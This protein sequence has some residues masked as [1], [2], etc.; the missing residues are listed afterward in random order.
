MVILHRSGE[1]SCLHEQA[2][3]FNSP[4]LDVLCRPSTKRRISARGAYET[5]VIKSQSA[6]RLPFGSQFSVE[7]HSILKPRTPYG[8]SR[9]KDVTRF[10]FS[11]SLDH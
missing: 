2:G 6:G 3:R 10:T 9:D 7:Y 5:T 4:D 1:S 8:P 11:H